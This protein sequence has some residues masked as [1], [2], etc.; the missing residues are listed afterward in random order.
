ME[1]GRRLY[2][3]LWEN[4]RKL[5]RVKTFVLDGR[6]GR[7]AMTRLIRRI[8]PDGVMSKSRF[9]TVFLKRENPNLWVEHVTS[10]CGQIKEAIARGILT[11]LEDGFER[12][13]N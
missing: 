10:T 13:R 11:S 4:P 2:G 5:G 9:M 8:R 7:Q 3:D 12:A 6:K 1:L